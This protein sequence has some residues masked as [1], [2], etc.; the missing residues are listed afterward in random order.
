MFSA[1][2]IGDFLACQH[3]TAL[4]RAKEAGEIERP[5][6]ADP[7]LDLLIR[8]GL[9]HEQAYLKSLAEGHSLA[10]ASAGRDAGGKG[11]RVVS[12]PADIPWKE[13]A[14]RTVE[15]IRDGAEVI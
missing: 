14:A 12:I 2:A 4:N 5:F 15:A 11:L 7:G 10:E 13:A 8:L 1:T 6:F 3:L 9:A